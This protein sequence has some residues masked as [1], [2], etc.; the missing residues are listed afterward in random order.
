MFNESW[1]FAYSITPVEYHGRTQTALGFPC[2][3]FFVSHRIWKMSQEMIVQGVLASLKVL[4]TSKNTCLITLRVVNDHLCICSPQELLEC[5]TPQILFLACSFNPTL[6]S[7]I[8]QAL[9][10]C[11][12]IMPEYQLATRVVKL[13]DP[14]QGGEGD[15]PQFS[16]TYDI[17]NCNAS[18]CKVLYC[19]CAPEG[20]LN[21]RV[22][23]SEEVS[24]ALY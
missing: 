21:R 13:P 14:P 10:D 7:V 5:F 16:F 24:P 15:Q 19:N 12:Q 23:H 1:F 17:Y 22:W 6:H 2:C 18:F 4:V 20:D 9:W 8:D 11:P 3:C